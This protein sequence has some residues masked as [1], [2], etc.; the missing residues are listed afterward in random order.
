MIG[1]DYPT[2]R[3]RNCGKIL[4]PEVL[5]TVTSSIRNAYEVISMRELLAKQLQYDEAKETLD[6]AGRVVGGSVHY[7][8]INGRS[9]NAP[10]MTV[11]FLFENGRLK[12]SSITFQ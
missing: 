5:C 3:T 11:E 4:A 10:A 12:V 8:D 7:K 2:T 1:I 9:S 6:E